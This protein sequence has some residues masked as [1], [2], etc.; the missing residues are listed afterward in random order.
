MSKLAVETR[1]FPL[2][3]VEGGVYKITVPVTSP[4]PVE[5]YLKAQGRYSHLL[6]P[7]NAFELQAQEGCRGE[8]LA[9]GEAVADDEPASRP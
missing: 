7:Q 3:E 1:F 2:Y 5:E 6:L 4:K 9:R 8:L